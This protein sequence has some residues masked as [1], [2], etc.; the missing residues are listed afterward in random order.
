MTQA[1]DEEALVSLDAIKRRTLRTKY[2][3]VRGE[4]LTGTGFVAERKGYQY[5]VT[6][7]HVVNGITPR[8]SIE[9]V[10]GG[11]RNTEVFSRV[12]VGAVDS[13]MSG[14]IDGEVDV[15]V[16]KLYRRLPQT[17][18]VAM[19]SAGL[20]A[21]DTVYALGFPASQDDSVAVNVESGTFTGFDAEGQLCI[22]GQVAKGMSGGPVMFVPEGQTSAEPQIAG[23]LAHIPTSP[24]SIPL[25][26]DFVAFDIQY[27]IELIDA[28]P[29]GL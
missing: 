20:T 23:I 14:E 9:I 15:A 1:N 27:A 4:L 18:P 25:P 8:G 7:H 22:D 16:L 6:A 24:G 11:R 19:S 3:N 21:G 17:A 29:R 13:A 28:N 5:L 26:L 12:G 10:D 2:L